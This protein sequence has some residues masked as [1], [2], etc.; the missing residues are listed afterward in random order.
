MIIV[1][2]ADLI[3]PESSSKDEKRHQLET[4]YEELRG[5][6]QTHSCPIWTAYQ[7]V[8]GFVTAKEAQQTSVRK[9]VPTLE[10][11]ESKKRTSGVSPPIFSAWIESRASSIQNMKINAAVMPAVC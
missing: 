7:S 6:S 4:I 5:I 2:Y 9:T 3:K 10:Q 8:S 11:S 1:D